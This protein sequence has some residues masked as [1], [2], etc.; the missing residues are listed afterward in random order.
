MNYFNEEAQEG[1]ISTNF[2][3]T[4]DIS[5]TEI[6]QIIGNRVANAEQ[7]WNQRLNL[8]EV[9]ETN[10]KY[11][12]GTYFDPK[13]LYD[14]QVPYQ[15]PRIFISIETLI[16]MALSRPPQPIVSQ[17]YDTDASKELARNLQDILLAKYED[18]YIKEKLMMV[19]RHLLMG[20]R[21]GVLKYSWD[22]TVGQLKD[23]GSRMGDIR[24]DVIRP[25][26]LVIE[27]GAND[28]NDIPLI[29]EYQQST[30]DQLCYKFP[31]KKD[32]ILKEG[33]LQAG[34]K[35]SLT[36]EVGSIEI[37]FSYYKDKGKQEAVAWKYN[38]LLLGSMKNPNW[39]YDEMVIGDDGKKRYTNFLDKPSKPYA[40]F[41]H[42]NTGRYVI[43]DTSLT[44]QAR[45]PQDVLDKRGRQIIENA[46]A[47]NSG[48]IFNSDMISQESAAQLIGDP[49]EKV[50][51]KGDVR[52][53]ATRLP[54]NG[55]EDYVVMDKQDSRS[56]IDNIF[57]THGAMRG[58]VSNSKTLGQDVLSQRGDISR[59]QTLA[60][61][62][63]NGAD[64]LYKG[65]VQ[66]MKV[67][68]DESQVIKFTGSD[69]KTSF[70]EFSNMSIE[71]GIKVRIKTG[72]VLPDDPI[73]RQE[74]TIQALAILDPLSIGEG[75]NKEDPKDFAK[76]LMYYRMFPD[77]YIMEYLNEDPMSSSIDPS[78]Q[79]EIEVMN[80]GQ[81][82]PPQQNPS[83]A[84]LATHDA[85]M[86]SPQFKGLPPEVQQLHTMHVQA[87]VD[88][89]KKALGQPV[90]NEEEMV[91]DA[92]T[93]TAP[94]E[95]APE[96]PQPRTGF[97]GAIKG[98]LGM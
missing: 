2:A 60:T 77:K 44:D 31:D 5:E 65:M 50:M 35:P 45:T 69:G 54:P 22:N 18:L 24:V 32:D 85:F 72:S 51:V 75:L 49:R 6:V 43:D 90:N 53:A 96:A 86:N 27:A 74:Q 16:P 91:G 92:N 3:L 81:E 78:A 10:E 42:L 67:F 28:I 68:Y 17:A 12:L 26:R 63:E 4:P 66:M 7:F 20:Y 40:L 46:D 1:E 37:W 52:S 73:S 83:K 93:Q 61:S 8:K 76:R 25:Q 21:L 89:A 84:H 87:E 9:R 88:N 33:G 58:E 19:T 41:N 11:W 38:T 59:I 80:S 23:D 95:Q 98:T 70:I 62:I 15:D 57:N 71:D 79:Q 30:L 64:R 29:G 47:A 13:K 34:V 94:T 55:L 36:K 14:H 56:I 39:N 82:A 97:M 48:L